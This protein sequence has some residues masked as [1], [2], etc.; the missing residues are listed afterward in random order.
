MQA[1]DSDI[2]K[3]STLNPF[4]FIK[5]K[6]LIPILQVFLVTKTFQHPTH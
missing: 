3:Q 4:K 1:S 6:P 5:R 2:V